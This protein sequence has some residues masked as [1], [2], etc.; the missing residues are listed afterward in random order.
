MSDTIKTAKKELRREMR[1]KMRIVGQDARAVL[2][3]L[4]CALVVQTEWFKHA[5]IILS[6]RP[7]PHE[8]S[9]EEIIE[10]TR[11]H[12]KTLVFPL[13]CEAGKLRLFAPNLDR[14]DE[15]F[16]TGVYGIL[17]PI[18]EKCIE[19]SI[20]DV[21]LVLAPGIAFSK[22]KVRLGQGGG[23]YD[24]ILEGHTGK[25]IGFCYPFQ[26]VD[27][28]PYEPHD[29]VMDAVVTSDGII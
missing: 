1:E 25:T 6:Y 11:K 3:H 29:A 13:C 24:R 23:Y 12:G 16:T 4:A 15:C 28:L 8:C 9:P 10:F 26:V 21:D 27:T 7:M 14:M 19:L 18:P 5:N 22:Q 17:E 20:A 2:S